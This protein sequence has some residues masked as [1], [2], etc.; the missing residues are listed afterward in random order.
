VRLDALKE[1]P[2]AFGSTYERERDLDEATWRSRITRRSTF[3]A[4]VDGVVAGTVATGDGDV[5]GASA[6]IAMW[7][8][9]RYRRRGVGDVLVKTVVD[10]AGERGYREM[11]LWVTA[12]NAAAE[13]LYARNGF[14]RTGASQEVRPR[15]LEYEMSRV[16]NAR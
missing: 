12:V 4:E 14:V 2:Y 9:P 7:V 8:D 13:R 10:W 3:V 6:V 5:A 16:L 15:E 1:A 11:F